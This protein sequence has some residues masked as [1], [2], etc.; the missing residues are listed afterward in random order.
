MVFVRRVMVNSQNVIVSW[1]LGS[2]IIRYHISAEQIYKIQQFINQTLCDISIASFICH[3][4]GA[5]ICCVAAPSLMSKIKI[6]CGKR[7]AG[8]TQVVCLEC[9]VEM[10]GLNSSEQWSASQKQ[11]PWSPAEVCNR[12]VSPY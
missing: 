1:F 4:L 9:R 10:L 7:F 2:L 3:R 8:W 5:G 12:K 6:S 11:P